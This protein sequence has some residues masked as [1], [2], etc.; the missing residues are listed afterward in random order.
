MIISSKNYITEFSFSVLMIVAFFSLYAPANA[1]IE[2]FEC[3]A[4]ES[5]APT[6]DELIAENENIGV[7]WVSPNKYEGGQ[8]VRNRYSTYTNTNKVYLSL[9]KPLRGDPEFSFYFYSAELPAFVPVEY[10]K[11]E[12]FHRQV[13]ENSDK[14]SVGSNHGLTKLFNGNCALIPVLLPNY[15]YL[16]FQDGPAA[17]SFEPIIDIEEDPLVKLIESSN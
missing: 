4:L 16:V 7:Y 10:F 6:V 5:R 12:K 3:H 8:S 9:V 15:Y 17:F 1:Q 14:F 13:A 2:E 11:I